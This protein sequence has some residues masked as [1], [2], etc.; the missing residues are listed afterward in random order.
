MSC[1]D[2]IGSPPAEA[3]SPGQGSKG[4]LSVEEVLYHVFYVTSRWLHVVCTTLIVGGTLFF[5]FVVPVAIEDLKREQQLAVFGK[6]RWMFRHVVWV[7][8]IILLLS[9]V[10]SLVRSWETYHRMEFRD[11][12]PWVFG[13]T[14]IGILALGVSLLLNARRRPPNHAVGWLRVSL[15]LLLLAIF[16]S[17]VAR[18]IRL[19][20]RDRQQSGASRS[21]PVL[22][23]PVQPE[24][25]SAP[26][27]PRGS[28]DDR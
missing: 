10:A 14:G 15:A 8:A 28:D 25:K 24:N 11:C 1:V 3:G 23:L 7:C 22:G 21:D 2:S 4:W 6:A 12:L 18:H 17:T 27:A 5:E 13:H 19:T 26:Q 9:G 16:A 20:V